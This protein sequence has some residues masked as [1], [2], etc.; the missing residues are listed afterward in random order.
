M[1]PQAPRR[2]VTLTVSITGRDKVPPNQFCPFKAWANGGAAPYTYSWTQSQGI[3]FDA[4]SQEY[5]A[6]SGFAYSVTVHVTG[7]D[8]STGSATKYVQV[9]TSPTCNL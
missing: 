5:W 2:T 3:G 7:S 4:T 1:R 6:K 9:G 8:G